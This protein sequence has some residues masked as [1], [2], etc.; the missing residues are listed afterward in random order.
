ME[1][2]IVY[3][4]PS[5]QIEE[6]KQSVELIK[7]EISK[8]IVGQEMNIDLILIAL[9]TEGH[10][11]LEGVPGVAKTLTANLLSGTI[12][13]GFS[14]IQ[15]TPDLMPS[16]VTGTSVFNYK[17]SEF[18]FKQGP[19]FSNIVLIDEINRSPAK[20]QASLFEVMQ[21][22]QI[23]SDGVTYSLDFPFIVIAT[24]NPVEQEGTYQLPEAQLDRFMFKLNVEYPSP[25]EEFEILKR[26]N[27]LK[28]GSE[29]EKINKVIDAATLKKHK[30]LIAHISIDDSLLKY[31][32]QAV[33]QTRNNSSLYLGASPRAS[34]AL[35]NG[36]KAFA[37]IKGRTY[38]TPEEIKALLPYVLKHRVVL[39]PE[40][41]ME[42]I[43]KSDVINE[44]ITQV[45][46]PR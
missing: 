1:D 21:E 4:S 24:Q 18:E 17:T 6:L 39:S 40:K 8:V 32:A 31:I 19:L 43:T 10:L 30:D 33:D 35:M 11:L 3:G 16:D 36:A 29:L 27:E 23:T 12:N 14:R 9:L 2:E 20:T 28:N 13:A 22:R 42:G 5:S 38:V 41:E 37:A 34:I 45:E 7:S 25:E 46:I 44:I 26:K 15:F